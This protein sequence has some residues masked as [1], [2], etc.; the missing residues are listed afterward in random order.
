MDSHTGKRVVDLRCLYVF[1]VLVL[2]LGLH[3]LGT[4][5]STTTLAHPEGITILGTAY[6]PRL[7]KLQD[8]VS[9]LYQKP[10][11]FEPIEG[12]KD[13]SILV[14]QKDILVSLHPGSTEDVV[15]HELMHCVLHLE[16]Y[17]RIFGVRGGKDAQLSLSV[18]DIVVGDLDHL[19]INRR[20]LRLGYDA[21]HGFLAHADRYD[22]PGGA[23]QWLKESY[24]S[25]NP[26]TMCIALIGAMHDLI[27]FKYYIGMKGSERYI[28]LKVPSVRP[29]WNRLDVAIRALPAQAKPQDIWKVGVVLVQESDRICAGTGASFRVSDLIG[30]NP[31]PLRRVETHLRA[32]EVFTET[33]TSET[34]GTLVRT[35]LRQDHILVGANLLLGRVPYGGEKEMDLSVSK[36]TAKRGI[37][38]LI[39]Q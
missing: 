14:R 36:F 31:V 29:Y 24:S 4:H 9:N 21:Q 12:N 35:F 11:S 37:K 19:V 3:P 13:D 34:Q 15:A 39:L 25:G 7:R 2:V 8:K 22:V 27:K 16:G 33:T 23:E 18:R 28:L 26:N 32:R 17:P 20:L 30:L 10:I 5:S 38:V 1:A 6:S